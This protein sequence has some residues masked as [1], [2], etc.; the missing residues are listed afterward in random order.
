MIQLLII[1]LFP[2]VIRAIRKAVQKKKKIKGLGNLVRINDY[3]NK[4]NEL[5]LEVKNMLKRLKKLEKDTHPVAD[6]VCLEC[7]CKATKKKKK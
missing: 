7:G 4:P 6:W 5:D 3:V 2:V 1:K